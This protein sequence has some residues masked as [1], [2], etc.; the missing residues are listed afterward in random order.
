M[1]PSGNG[2]PVVGELL[3]SAAA[4]LGDVAAASESSSTEGVEIVRGVAVDPD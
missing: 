3:R 2:R 1:A 4:S